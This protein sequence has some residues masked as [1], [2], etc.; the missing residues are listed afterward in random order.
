MGVLSQ[1]SI[2]VPVYNRLNLLVSTLTSIVSQTH[3]DWI[4]YICDD[5]SDENV[6]AVLC[7]FNEPRFVYHRFEHV[8][9]GGIRNRGLQMVRSPYVVM[10]D[11]D[12]IWHPAFLSQ[13][14]QYLDS[15][16][17]VGMV[18]TAQ[19]EVDYDTNYLGKRNESLSSSTATGRFGDSWFA[20]GL[21]LDYFLTEPYGQNNFS[22]LV[23]RSGIAKTVTMEEINFMEDWDYCLKLGRV[24]VEI[25]Y[26]DEE[27]CLYRV[28]ER[29]VDLVKQ[30][31][32]LYNAISM[33]RNHTFE[34]R[35]QRSIRQS[36]IGNLYEMIAFDHLQLDHRSAASIAFISALRRNVT[37]RR[38]YGL[39]RCLAPRL[40]AAIKTRLT[41]LGVVS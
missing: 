33:L 8:G 18:Q 22:S 26:L 41:K 39:S 31:T 11:S 35:W 4:A 13:T 6:E 40:T 21:A 30:V 28:Y 36:I 9:I 5:G 19:G 20:V 34:Q 29:Q 10:L 17:L 27:L 1:V 12:D 3:K 38:L 16:P 32:S 14:V 37:M 2:I 15:Y 25:A 7:S 23:M 24:G